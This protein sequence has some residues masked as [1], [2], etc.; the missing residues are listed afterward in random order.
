MHRAKEN[1]A[2]SKSE[3]IGVPACRKHDSEQKRGQ[4]TR[5]G[6]PLA[7]S[8]I[9]CAIESGDTKDDGSPAIPKRM[10]NRASR[11]GLRQYNGNSESDGDKY[12]NHHGIHMMKGKWQQHSVSPAHKPA[13]FNHADL[14]KDINVGEWNALGR[15]G[16]ARSIEQQSP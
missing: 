11:Q 13:F 10:C 14:R 8:V 16:S 6:N 15:A 4:E 3:S 2:Q 9:D 7:N 5:S 1:L 12:S